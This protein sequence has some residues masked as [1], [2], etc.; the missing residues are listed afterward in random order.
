[1][2]DENK[3]V[4]HLSVSLEIGLTAAMKRPTHRL[5]QSIALRRS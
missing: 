5:P 2:K 1:V 4:S 3:S